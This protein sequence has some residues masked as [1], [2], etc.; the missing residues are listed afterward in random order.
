MSVLINKI[1]DLSK[2]INKNF[3]LSS[4]VFLLSI[5][6]FS[7]FLFYAFGNLYSNVA[8]TLRIVFSILLLLNLT[9]YLIKTYLESNNTQNKLTFEKYSN[10][11][12]KLIFFSIGIILLNSLLPEKISNYG[13]IPDIFSFFVT[14]LT[15][16]F[17]ILTGLY[18]LY[19]LFKWLWYRR[20]KK[21]KRYILI[22]F[23]VLT[24]LLLFELPF[25]YYRL[26]PEELAGFTFV[27][28][29]SLFLVFSILIIIFLI[30]KK[31]YWIAVLSKKEKLKLLF[32]LISL[33]ILSI[34]SFSIS[35]EEQGEGKFSIA[36]LY[37]FGADTII[38]MSYFFLIPYIIRLL[39]ATIAALPTSFIVE[40]T[41]NELSSLAYLNRIVAQTIDHNIL[42]NTLTE[43]AINTCRGIASWTEI[44][45]NNSIKIVAK[46][47][48]SEEH[49]R[50]LNGSN[51]LHNFLKSINKPIL[52]PSI[53]E[54]SRVHHI[55]WSM[56][57]YVNSLI[58]VPLFSRNIRVGTLVILHP[59]EF[60]LEEDDLTVMQA[61]S[62]N[63]NVA[64]ENI[65]LLKDSI[66]KEK[67]KK[68]LELARRMEEKLLPEKLP[69]IKNYS[70][71]AFSIPAKEVGGDYYDVFKLKNGKFCLLIGDVSGKGMSAAFYMAQ[72]RG[73][74]LAVSTSSNSGKELLSKINDALYGNI[75]KSMYIT[76]SSIVIDD[77][78]G[79]IT[80][81][82]A[83]H[84][85]L[86]IKR[87]NKIDLLTPKGLGLGLVNNNVF[88]NNLE[89]IS[90]SLLSGDIC[91][92]FT[93]GIN[94]L[95]DSKNNEFSI[96]SLQNI[97][98]KYNKILADELLIEIKKQLFEFL[99]EQ[100]IYDD[101]S[102]MV[103]CYCNTDGSFNNE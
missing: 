84:M 36:V 67:Y 97:L 92:L 45:D 14:E 75:E 32:L 83:G 103:L 90:I 1:L 49:I 69:K 59:E 86:M 19:F 101:M 39:F 10:D 78:N 13:D 9:L 54:D 28:I 81:T 73:I 6:I 61:F 72:L 30:A 51:N 33:L 82:R 70:I 53:N 62:D 76:M 63:V 93:D 95:R 94:E 89:E 96:L 56:F 80:F 43:L 66:E 2:S 15:S 41:T 85:P 77:N 21:T 23:W 88:D 55:N 24:V 58:A 17:S 18:I 11:L 102:M 12:I 74:V 29:F 47:F 34:I 87:Q 35:M 91:I 48:I 26:S 68:E 16:V 5:K 71:S 22:L 37:T 4:A 57:P 52:I 44:Y 65:A 64:L 27:V 50:A 100:E 42:F 3:I 40:R 25:H 99:G 79:H 20:H 38:F 60:G 31:N 46:Q 98:V 8:I 7:D